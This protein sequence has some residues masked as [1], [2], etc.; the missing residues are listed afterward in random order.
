MNRADLIA[1]M[2]AAVPLAIP[3]D[4]P[5]WGGTTYVRALT[6]ADVDARKPSIPD[7]D[8]KYRIAIM[9][10]QVI[11]DETGARIFDPSNQEDVDLVSSQHWNT[12]QSIL[13]ESNKFT[14]VGEAK[15]G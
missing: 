6:V 5:E 7:P 1:A 15:N 3:I 12:L 9:L 11:C 4:T 13:A 8:G 10:C 14:G 2:R